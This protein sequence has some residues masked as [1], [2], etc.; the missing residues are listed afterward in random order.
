MRKYRSYT[1]EDLIKAVK[2]SKSVAEVLR[3]LSLREAGGNFKTIKI[4]IAQLSLDTSH[5]TGMLWS[6]GQRV[7]EWASYKRSSQLK[8]H[9]IK[10]RGNTCEKC[11]QSEWLGFSIPLEVHHVDGNP[12]N[13]VLENLQLLCCNCHA[14]TD[15]WRNR[16]RN[17]DVVKWQTQQT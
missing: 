4:K 2:E 15:N 12:T 3:C 6:K 13:N 11:L 1:E 10:D 8:K 17:A 9:L 16:K 14:T 7:K 5:F